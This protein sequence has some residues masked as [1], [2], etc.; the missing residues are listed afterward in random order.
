VRSAASDLVHLLTQLGG[1]CHLHE[2]I[3]YWRDG[4]RSQT[5]LAA[6]W[7]VG[8][9]RIDQTSSTVEAGAVLSADNLAV[10]VEDRL[11]GLVLIRAVVQKSTHVPVTPHQNER[12][13]P[14]FN[15]LQRT[16]RSEG[17]GDDD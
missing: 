11:Q 10:A 14:C 13:P 2:V 8:L 4:D 7:V 5:L 3:R 9:P 17:D 1:N 6:L 15:G 16:V 12:N